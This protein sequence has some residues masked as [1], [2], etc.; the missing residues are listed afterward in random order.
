MPWAGRLPRPIGY[1]LGGGAAY[2]AVQVG[3]LQ[4]LAETDLLPD[5]VVGT[6]V[7]SLNGAILA[8]EPVAAAH[9][10]T[11]IWSGV[12][13]EDVFPRGIWGAYKSL[14]AARPYIYT[15]DALAD[16]ITGTMQA[17]AFADLAVPFAAVATDMADGQA[18]LLREGPLRPALLASAAIPAVF[19]WVEI[20]G[21]RYVDGGV[22]SNVPLREACAMGAASLVVLDCGLLGIPGQQPH[23][24]AES[25]IHAGA[26]LARQQVV[27]DLPPVARDRPV[28][29]LPGPFPLRS[30]AVDFDHTE[31]LAAA[32]YALSR[33]FL[34]ALPP[35]E[36]PLE[37]GLY[38][39][40]ALAA[41]NSDVAAI[42][43]G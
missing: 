6:S 8:E 7:G 38:G 10:L 40:P 11:H 20:G 23:T 35:G 27:R 39:D 17:R 18:T 30:L 3:M 4:A 28:V 25:L 12:R 31:D 32:A 19:P 16:L 26:L 41:Q 9:R 36:G 43:R 1:V 42:R 22:A 29:Y 5:L 33:R 13:R 2:G 24:I 15:A 14:V 34:H 21:R 37:A